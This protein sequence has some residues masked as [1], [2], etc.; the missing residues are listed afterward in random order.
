MHTHQHGVG[1]AGDNLQCP[2]VCIPKHAYPHHTNTHSPQACI[3][4]PYKYTQPPSMHALCMCLGNHSLKFFNTGW[5]DQSCALAIMRTTPIHQHCLLSLYTT[6]LCYGERARGALWVIVCVIGVGGGV[7]G[8]SVC[9]VQQ[10]P[11]QQH[12]IHPIQQHPIQRHPIQHVYS[13]TSC[14][15]QKQYPVYPRISADGTVGSVG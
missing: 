3:P 7:V 5:L 12:P 2:V 4:T 1:C 10:H 6:M 8:S 9:P 11:V 15:S 13:P 14:V